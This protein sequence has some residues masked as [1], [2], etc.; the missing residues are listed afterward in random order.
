MNSKNISLASEADLAWEKL[1]QV[2]KAEYTNSKKVTELKKKIQWNEKTQRA[3][4]IT[5]LRFAR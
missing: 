4:E 3:F 2:V 5:E 1:G